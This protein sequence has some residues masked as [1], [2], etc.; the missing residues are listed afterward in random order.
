M[1]KQPF[2]PHQALVNPQVV[3]VHGDFLAGLDDL[4]GGAGVHHG[5]DLELSGQDRQIRAVAL[6]MSTTM[7]LALWK[8]M[9]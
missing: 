4:G 1:A 2:R 7:A 6:P 5:R 9:P 8:T 3:G